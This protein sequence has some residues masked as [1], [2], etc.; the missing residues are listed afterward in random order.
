VVDAGLSR[1]FAIDARQR[2]SLGVS[3][4]GANARYLQTWYGVTPAQSAASGYAVYEPGSGLRDIGA[5]ATWRIEFDPQWAGF[6]SLGIGRLVGPA[7]DSPLVR[8]AGR[9]SVSAGIARR[10]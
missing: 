2:F 5:S 9:A 10:F 7:A 6:T 4:S 1:S 3:V 8:R